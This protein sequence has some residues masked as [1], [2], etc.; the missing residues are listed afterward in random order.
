MPEYS[1]SSKAKLRTCDPDL[2]K[3]FN[4]VIE[5]LDNSILEGHRDEKTQNQY[6]A[7]GKSKVKFPFSK[8]NK[9]PSQAVDSVPYPI[10]WRFEG[11][12]I[13]HIRKY[14]DLKPK[15]ILNIADVEKE[16]ISIVENI[17]RWFMYIGFVRGVASHMGIK[18]RSGADWNSD[19][20][21]SDQKFN[22]LPHFELIR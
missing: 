8:H 10:D 21:T 18:L 16:I 1:N 17:E 4:F 5:Y 11:A 15:S 12:L 7:Q 6:F 2:Q 3:L 14:L 19:G 20:Y 9:L 13:N 22:D